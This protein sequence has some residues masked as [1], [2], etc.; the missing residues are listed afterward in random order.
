MRKITETPAGQSRTSAC[1][2]VDS[3]FY[4]KNGAN[5]LVRDTV[6]IVDDK[7]HRNGG[8][9]RSGLRAV[10]PQRL[11]RFQLGNHLSSAVSELDNVAQIISYEDT[12]RTAATYEA[13]RSK[14]E[15]PKRYRYIGKERDD[16]SG[17]HYHGARYYVAWLA[18]WAAPDPKLLIDGTNLYVYVRDSPISNGQYLWLFVVQDQKMDFAPSNSSSA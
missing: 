13:V 11:I 10:V 12:L 4:R 5:P 15:S 16:E 7:Q 17:L 8:D 18:R 14:T 3:R 1:I 2:W 9:A 6:H